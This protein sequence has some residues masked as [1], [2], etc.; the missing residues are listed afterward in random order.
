MKNNKT[1]TIKCPFHEEITPSFVIHKEKGFYHC[2]GCGKHGRLIEL[3]KKI[4]ALAGMDEDD[5]YNETYAIKFYLLK[6]ICE[7]FED[8]PIL[9]QLEITGIIAEVLLEIDFIEMKDKFKHKIK[10]ILEREE[11]KENNF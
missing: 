3:D 11:E 6:T 10:E 7:K 4:L 5:I 1:V 8:L 2:F 9:A